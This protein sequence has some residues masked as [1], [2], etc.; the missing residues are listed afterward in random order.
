[1][2][3][4]ISIDRSIE[5]VKGKRHVYDIRYYRVHYMH[6]YVIIDTH[7]FIFFFL[8]IYIYV[9]SHMLTWY[10]YSA[11]QSI[12]FLATSTGKDRVVLVYSDNI[13]VRSKVRFFSLLSSPL[14]PSPDHPPIFY[15]YYYNQKIN[16]FCFL[17]GSANECVQQ[18]W[19]KNFIFFSWMQKRLVKKKFLI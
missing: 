3:R 19:K 14:P 18:N 5:Y 16:F 4:F 7:I 10:C 13:Q 12:P 2:W 17:L 15:Y 1:M 9:H 8:N 11:Q 6:A